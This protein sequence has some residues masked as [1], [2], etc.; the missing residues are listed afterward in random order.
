MNTQTLAKSI[1][2]GIAAVAFSAMILG[3]ARPSFAGLWQYSITI[4][5]V[6]NKE[7]HDHPRAYLWTPPKCRRVRAVVVAQHNLLEE[8]ILVDPKFRSTLA[9]LDM[10]EVWVMPNI[11]YVFDFDKGA[12]EAFDQAMRSLA[13]ESGY[14]ELANAPVVPL[15]H[16][17]AASFP[18]NFAAWAPDRT[19]AVLS[20][21]GDMPE[22]NL[23]GS[24][25]PN[26]NWGDRNIDGVPGL[27]A[28][29]QYEWLDTRTQPG[30]D[31][32]AK[33]PMTPVAMLPDIGHGHFDTSPS[34]VSFLSMFL[35]KAAEYRLP[36]NA[37]VDGPVTLTPI[38]PRQGWLVDRWEP[39]VGRKY[40]IAR[41][42]EY[43]GDR[44][45]AFW[46]F[47]REMAEATENYGKGR[48][49]NTEH[50]IIY[51]QDGKV[52]AETPGA[53][54][55]MPRPKLE[56]DADG[57]T[58]HFSAY[59]V[60]GP[61]APGT[62]WTDAE[63]ASVGARQLS[64]RV[65]CGPVV[66]VDDNTYRLQFDQSGFNSPYRSFN[67]FITTVIPDDWK[68]MVRSEPAGVFVARNT[69]GADN[70]IT[71]PA[72]GDITDMRHSIRLNATASSGLPVA[73][74]VDSG[75]ADVDGDLLR[76]TP[77]PPRSKYPLTVRVVAWQWGRSST[78]AVK[79][80][81]PVVVTFR[82]LK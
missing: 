18:W 28:M 39:G 66:K 55:V 42:A 68:E 37:P 14:R 43:Q 13:A 32:V 50:K 49:L 21:H 40:S 2:R 74:Y 15:G 34:L 22:S 8:S 11:D 67:T 29:G 23:T 60:N 36:K 78:P 33:H 1:G 4:D 58:F 57:R 27:F 17:A 3:P 31:Y 19:L 71:F 45:N 38:D 64:P 63:A 53:A 56:T 80:A 9:K 82:I 47:D 16:S 72:I 54:G 52:L 73:Y 26:P 30:L 51:V 70:V 35:T 24:G 41:Y 25:R 59:V 75:P 44:N 65:L 62:E 81:D 12:G 48:V 20:V 6:N 79:S 76:F 5:S 77:I 46:C 61:I 10:A 69:T 7:I